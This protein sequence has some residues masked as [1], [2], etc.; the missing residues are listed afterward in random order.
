MDTSFE[1]SAKST[2]EWYTPPSI[3]ERLGK[4]DLD[5]CAPVTPMWKIAKTNY[6]IIDDGL[7]KDWVGRVW[8]NPPY[9]RPVLDRF[10]EKLIFHGNGIALLFNRCDCRLFQDLLFNNAQGILFIKGR[11]KF[12]TQDGKQGGTPGCGSVLVAFGRENAEI[13]KHSGIQGKYF[14]I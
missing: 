6:N 1:K 5:P 11:V 8:L 13:L 2:D 3:F 9:S 14:E 4:F 7:T 12:Y 10:V